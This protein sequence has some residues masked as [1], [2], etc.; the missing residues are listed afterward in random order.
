MS[1]A[2]CSFA[3]WINRGGFASIQRLLLA[4]QELWDFAQINATKVAELHFM[5][6]NC[7]FSPCLGEKLDVL[8]QS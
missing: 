2:G 5:G 1:I 4:G 3:V 8:R 7:T 6:F